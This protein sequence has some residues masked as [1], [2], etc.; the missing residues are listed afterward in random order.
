MKHSLSGLTVAVHYGCHFPH[1]ESASTIIDDVESPRV[2]E[3]ILQELGANVVPYKEQALCCGAGLNQRIL[4]EDR[5]NSLNITLRK[6]KSIRSTQPDAIIVVCPYCELHMD[7]AQ[8]E[9]EVEFDEEFDIPVLHIM[10][11]LGILLEVPAEKLGLGALDVS[12][13]EIKE[14]L[15]GG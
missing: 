5:I 4:H 9:L 15:V 8:V 7:S 11:L 14:K 2:L 10:E 6:M 12:V 3:E 13:D 1:Q